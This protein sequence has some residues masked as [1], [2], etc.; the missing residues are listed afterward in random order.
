MKTSSG[1]FCFLSLAAVSSCGPSVSPIS[2]TKTDP[3]RVPTEAQKSAVR[4]VQRGLTKDFNSQ[5]LQD[6][7]RRLRAII[8]EHGGEGTYKGVKLPKSLRIGDNVAKLHALFPSGPNMVIPTT[9]SAYSLSFFS[10]DTR[11]TLCTV[12]VVDQMIAYVDEQVI[13]QPQSYFSA[14]PAIPWPR[15]PSALADETVKRTPGK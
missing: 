7:E 2:E 14:Y 12:L 13:D 10:V 4:P 11:R 9:P 15:V 3:P 6:T 1:L 8:K 5:L